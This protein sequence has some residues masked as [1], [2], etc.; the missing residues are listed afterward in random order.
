MASEEN[1]QRPQLQ[2]PKIAIS[3]T[4]SMYNE[5]LETQHTAFGFLRCYSPSS[6]MIYTQYP[7]AGAN[8]GSLAVQCFLRKV[9][10]N[11]HRY[12]MRLF[13]PSSSP[14]MRTVL[15]EVSANQT[16][17]LWNQWCMLC[18]KLCSFSFLGSWGSHNIPDIF[19]MCIT[20]EYPSLL[21]WGYVPRYLRVKFQL[22]KEIIPMPSII[23]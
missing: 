14:T 5:H 11:H 13:W 23:M 17:S 8:L 21:P 20:Y 7:G 3:I 10:S 1:T 16:C 18:F 22:A 6:C 4:S 19:S 9:R 15:K 2:A 12:F